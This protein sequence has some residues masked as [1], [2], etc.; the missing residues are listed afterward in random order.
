MKKTLQ[1]LHTGRQMVEQMDGKDDAELETQ[2]REAAAELEVKLGDIMMPL[3][4]AVTGSTISPPLFESL[5]LLGSEKSLD[6]LD[7][8]ITQISKEVG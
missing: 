6:R 3:R 5:R 1:I 7:R 8:A 4:V 2:Y